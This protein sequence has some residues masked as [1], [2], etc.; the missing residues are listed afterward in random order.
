M[1]P[2]E[3]QL[4]LSETL[5]GRYR[6]TAHIG[7]GGFAG[8]FSANDQQAGSV[9]DVA[10]KILKLNQCG[11]AD[12]RQEFA[13]E[14]RLL[15]M[16]QGCDRVV[17]V[18]DSGQHTVHLRHPSVNTSIPVMTE[19]SVLEL[20]AGSLAALLLHGP[21]LGWPDRLALYRDVVKGI[22]QMHLRRI[23]HRD[24]K[25]E[26]VLVFEN[27][28]VA[29]VTDLGRAH[30]TSEQPRFA[31]DAYIAGRG[32]LRFAPPEFLWLQGTQDPE[33]QALADIYL[34]GALLFEVATGVYFTSML[35]PNTMAVVQ[36]NA[37]LTDTQRRHAWESRVP[38][39]RESARPVYASFDASVPAAIRGR[40]GEL[41]RL[42]TDPDPTRRLPV[43]PG[44]REAISCW[45][46]EWLL[47]RVDGLRRGIDTSFR[48]HYLKG[49][50][51]PN[52]RH[53]VPRR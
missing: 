15:Q 3:I 16:L 40:T 46:L 52:R 29:K 23:V 13:D 24:L 37:P 45:N 11:S 17:D 31:A 26:N 48:K 12:A 2:G 4:F 35:V 6:P 53:G 36:A 5:A 39:L 9:A 22:H 34:L 49:R 30:D 41:L 32:D 50:P 51:R 8:T 21:Q 10:V 43:R 25:A 19:F 28:Q 38:W 14:V 18:L 20:A 27:P 1:D 42:L 7:S 47:R 44:S 33:D